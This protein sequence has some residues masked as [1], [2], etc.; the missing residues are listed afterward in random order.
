VTWLLV[1]VVT[2]SAAMRDAVLT[3]TQA[4]IIDAYVNCGEIQFVTS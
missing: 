1:A 4:V 2:F 3:A